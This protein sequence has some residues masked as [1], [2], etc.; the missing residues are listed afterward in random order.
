MRRSWK[1][2]AAAQAGECSSD[3]CSHNL[4]KSTKSKF[5]YV[6]AQ[7]ESECRRCRAVTRD[8]PPLASFLYCS[9]SSRQPR[10]ASGVPGR[11]GGPQM[12]PSLGVVCLFNKTCCSRYTT[13]V[14]PPWCLF[15]A[16]LTNWSFRSLH[17]V[18]CSSCRRYGD[19]AGRAGGWQKT[20]P[21][22][23]KGWTLFRDI[24]INIWFIHFSKSASEKRKRWKTRN[25]PVIGIELK[26]KE[27]SD[28][29]VSIT[30]RTEQNLSLSL[31][32]SHF[33]AFYYYY[34]LVV[35]FLHERC[36]H[37]IVWRL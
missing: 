36:F 21:S 18:F 4:L 34:Y 28:W 11:H 1:E 24:T 32:K 29:T 7:T 8:A 13:I 23:S 6:I 16:C 12:A 22:R 15:K 17:L 30:P 25:H 37:W 33:Y 19:T 20:A 10:L 9:R 35:L 5:N 27:K 31:K 3:I 14:T 26:R 2:A